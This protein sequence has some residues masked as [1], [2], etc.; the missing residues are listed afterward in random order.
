[1]VLVIL[2][3]AIKMQ[4]KMRKAMRLRSDVSGHNI[5]ELLG[6]MFLVIS[7]DAIEAQNGMRKAMIV[8]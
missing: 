7:N 6:S 1:M 8:Y 3:D 4:N 2:D 5:I